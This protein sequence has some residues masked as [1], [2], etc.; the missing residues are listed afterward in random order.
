MGTLKKIRSYITSAIN[1][2]RARQSIP[3]IFLAMKTA[4]ATKHAEKQRPFFQK[5]ENE[6]GQLYACRN[7]QQKRRIITTLLQKHSSLYGPD[8]K[9]PVATLSR[10][11]LSKRIRSLYLP[12][13]C[14]YS[15][16]MLHWICDQKAV[17]RVASF[18]GRFC[19]GEEVLAHARRS[20]RN[21]G[22]RA[23]LCIVR[24]HISNLP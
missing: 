20:H 12:C 9:T 16:E 14:R 6:K 15:L 13:S 7:Q 8:S 17:C 3:Q 5:R 18:P 23:R 22:I 11:T 19:G 4:P 10:N 2:I 21:M 24:L 1:L